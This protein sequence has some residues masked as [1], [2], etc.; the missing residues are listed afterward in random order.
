M[1]YI[2]LFLTAKT[3]QNIKQ[4]TLNT[5][6]LSEYATIS[7]NFFINVSQNIIKYICKV[8]QNSIIQILQYYNSL[9]KYIGKDIQKTKKK[10]KIGDGHR[11]L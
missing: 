3:Q 11:N 10:K 6:I 7:V 2:F 5:N 9:K 4:K 8:L 1:I